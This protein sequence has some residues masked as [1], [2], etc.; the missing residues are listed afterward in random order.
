M[1][2]S[3]EQDANFSKPILQFQLNHNNLSR[4][5]NAGRG[6]VDFKLSQ[7]YDARVNVEVKYSSN[8]KLVDGYTKQLPAYNRA[9]RTRYSIYLVIRNTFRDAKRCRELH[10]AEQHAVQSGMRSPT[11]IEVDGRWK[12]SA[13]TL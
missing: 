9:E 2:S 6:P 7:G 13:S 1:E 11:I 5:P 8:T 3:C 4:E 12:P 10:E